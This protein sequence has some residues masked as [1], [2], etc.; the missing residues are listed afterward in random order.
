MENSGIGAALS[1]LFGFGKSA[2]ALLE[3]AAK[4]REA[5]GNNRSER[6]SEVAAQKKE[7]SKNSAPP[8]V[9]DPIPE[10]EPPVSE[11]SVPADAAPADTDVLNQLAELYVR[12]Y[13]EGAGVTL[14]KEA[15]DAK[16]AEVAK[17]Y[18][19]KQER[20]DLVVFANDT[21]TES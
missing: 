10:E 12:Q 7:K 16:T 11:P 14:T 18:E 2:D 20:L 4:R 21:A 3:E 1:G 19:N 9:V 5:R 6:A 17:F 13:E 15:R 8:E